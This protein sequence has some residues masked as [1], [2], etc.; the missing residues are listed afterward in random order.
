VRRKES[1]KGLGERLEDSPGAAIVGG[2]TQ[3]KKIDKREKKIE[4][5]RIRNRKAPQRKWI[6]TRK[7]VEKFALASQDAK[8]VTGG[9]KKRGIQGRNRG[10]NQATFLP[11]FSW[12]MV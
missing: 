3:L 4:K 1:G 5:E 12:S 9:C 11:S 2:L 6:R 8:G 10:R 7:I